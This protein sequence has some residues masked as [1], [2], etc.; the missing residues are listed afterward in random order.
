[1]TRVLRRDYSKLTRN[2]SGHRGGSG[3]FCS[4]DPLGKSPMAKQTRVCFQASKNNEQG[5]G[6][7]RERLDPSANWVSM[8]PRT[9]GLSFFRRGAR[10]NAGGSWRHRDAVGA[11]LVV[12]LGVL[13]TAQVHGAAED[14]LL[15]QRIIA[16]SWPAAASACRL[17]LT[18]QP[19][20][21]F[22]A[23][24]LPQRREILHQADIAGPF[25]LEGRSDRFS[26]RWG[27]HAR[28]HEVPGMATTVRCKR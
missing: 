8:A 21:E 4:N 19:Q 28:R 5:H 2:L 25:G 15:A 3:S 14:K 6:S 16:E 12:L 11:G 13:W 9:F 22:A 24:A 1:M 26:L 7:S 27:I 20:P 17:G 23:R 10:P 18:L